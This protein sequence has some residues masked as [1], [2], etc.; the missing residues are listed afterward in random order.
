MKNLL[1]KGGATVG[2]EQRHTA[3]H[4]MGTYFL[5]SRAHGEVRGVLPR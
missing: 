3:S 1:V 5:I 4:F 2:D